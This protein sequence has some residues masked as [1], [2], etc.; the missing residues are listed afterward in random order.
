VE[1]NLVRWSY[2]EHVTHTDTDDLEL[3]IRWLEGHVGYPYGWSD[4][5]TAFLAPFKLPFYVVA[6]KRYHCSALATQFLA[7]ADGFH[8]L[9]DLADNP[10]RV[11]PGD[12]ARQ[13]GVT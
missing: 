8:V 5:E 11:T 4:I 10:H 13:L 12:L 2:A 1:H 3:A 7:F 6:E 9:G